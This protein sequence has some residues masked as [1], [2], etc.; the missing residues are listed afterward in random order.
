MFYPLKKKPMILF[1]CNKT[2][3]LEIYNVH[4]KLFLF[5]PS[6][7]YP[8][9]IAVITFVSISYTQHKDAKHSHNPLLIGFPSK[10]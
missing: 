7:K 6:D 8:S 3:Y 1:Y 9:I 5:I 2:A 10:M 4:R